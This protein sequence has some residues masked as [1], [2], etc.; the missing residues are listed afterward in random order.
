MG[1]SHCRPTVFLRGSGAHWDPKPG[2][3]AAGE[4]TGS[5]GVI[6]ARESESHLLS[7]F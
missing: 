4:A 2:L 7:G 3:A 5:M 1:L 6:P